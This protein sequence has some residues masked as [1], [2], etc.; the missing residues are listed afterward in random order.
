MILEYSN[1]HIAMN[2]SFTLQCECISNSE[3]MKYYDKKIEYTYLKVFI[4]NILFK[5]EL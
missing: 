2:R 1:M 4:Y 5:T 3:Y